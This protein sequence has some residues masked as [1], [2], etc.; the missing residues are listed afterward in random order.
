MEKSTLKDKSVKF[1]LWVSIFLCTTFFIFEPIKSY[2][3][4]HEEYWFTLTK[5]MKLYSI[6]WLSGVIACTLLYLLIAHF[7]NYFANIL[8][9][10]LFFF[11][12][13][14]VFTR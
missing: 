1:V 13:W 2:Y 6:C 3:A 4:N 11:L 8:Y 9:V 10:I 12:S 14:V 7:N 5:A